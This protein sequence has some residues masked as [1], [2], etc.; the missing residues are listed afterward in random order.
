MYEG[1]NGSISYLKSNTIK[2][3]V[4]LKKYMILLIIQDRPGGHN[5]N[6][7]HFILGEQLFKLK[8]IDMRT[9]LINGLLENSRSKATPRALKSKITPLHLLHL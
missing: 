9:A 5:Y 3:L 6:P 4:N 7:F 1:T 8:A 2:Q